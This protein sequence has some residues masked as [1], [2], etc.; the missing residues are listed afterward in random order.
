MDDSRAD[1]VKKSTNSKG[2]FFRLLDAIDRAI[3]RGWR[4]F[5]SLKFGMFLLALIGIVSIWGTMGFASNAALGE[6][7]IPMAR[8]LVFESGYFS[9]LLLLFAANLIFSTWH[10]TKMSVGIWWKRDFRRSKVFYEHGSSPRGEVRVPGGEEEV[11]RVLGRHFTRTHQDGNAFFAHRGILSRLGP[12]IV[13]IGIL[14]VIGSIV[15]KSFLLDRGMVMTEGRFIAAEGE[16]TNLVFEPIAREQNIT[17]RNNRPV[18]L[19]VWIKVLDF[20]EIMHPNSNVPAHFTSLLEIRDPRTNQITVAQLDMNHSLKIPM[21]RYG[22]L[23][24]HQAGYQA[25][26]DGEFQRVNFDVRDTATGERIA[27]T[28]THPNNRVRI[29]E[30]EFFLEVDAVAPA[31]RWRIYSRQSPL[32][33]V[34][35][36]LLTGGQRLEYSFRPA[37]FF[38]DFRIDESTGQPRNASNMP[39]NPALRVDVLMNDRQVATTWLFH[40]RQLAEI[41]PDIHPRYRL[42]LADVRVPPNVELETLDW[43]QPRAAI[44]QIDVLDRETGATISEE[45]V[46]G[47][48]S[49]TFVYTAEVSHGTVAPLGTEN[50]FEVRIIGPTQRYLTTLSVVNEPTVFYTILGVLIIMVGAMMT[51]L[52]RYRAFYG[53]WDEDRQTLR[54]ALVPRWGQ[55]PVREEF[56]RLVQVLSHGA[57]LV[58]KEDGQQGEDEIAPEHESVNPRLAEATVE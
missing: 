23:Q 24:F 15:I 3:L 1:F 20:D 57:G 6:N 21:S 17:D 13:H 4:V 50:G 26:E 5:T 32:E 38:P 37:E 22:H 10:V 42:D 48:T 54:M 49:R 11:R 9:A 34:A 53:M 35:E 40:D 56:D 44:Y 45:L 30:T 8:T 19:D 52:F 47:E 25:V 18:A 28:D 41:V 29:G 12:T 2:L 55:S 31:S 14:T 33:P 27:V 7:S 39:L 51:F 36:G 43:K 46:L 58:K 16:M